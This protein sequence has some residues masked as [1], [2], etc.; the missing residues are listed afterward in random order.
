MQGGRAK[1][2]GIAGDRVTGGVADLTIDAFDACVGLY[3]CRAGFV[4]GFDGVIAGQASVVHPF[5]GNPF[6]KE[7]VHIND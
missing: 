2:V 1:I 4:D 7:R 3:P 5:G 6:V